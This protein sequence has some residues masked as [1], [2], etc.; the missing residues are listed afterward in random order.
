MKAWLDEL[1]N[2]KVDLQIAPLIDCVFLLLI[3]F[4]VSSSLKRSEA[5]LGLSLPGQVKQTESMAMPDEQVIEVRA[6][7]A[8]VFNDQEYKDLLKSDLA[9][10]EQTLLRYREASWLM[11]AQPM[12][13][14]IADN[15]SIHGRVVDVLNACAGAGIKNV[16]FANVE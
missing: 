6:D 15:N 11:D 2:E 5:D 3:Y 12:I 8:I 7:G 16:T 13:T 1:I 10:L 4:M 9:D 14:I